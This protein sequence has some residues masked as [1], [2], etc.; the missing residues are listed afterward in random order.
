[1]VDDRGQFWIA[2]VEAF[3]S[4]GA[5][6]KHYCKRHGLTPRTFRTWRTRIMGG[7]KPIALV[8]HENP[9]EAREGTKT[10]FSPFS[11]SHPD[12]SLPGELLTNSRTRRRW[13]PEQKQQIV[14]AALRSGMSLERFS[15]VLGLTPSVV[16]RWKHELAARLQ[17]EHANLPIPPTAP[18]FATVHV[19]S[20]EQ[21]L[22][23][24]DPVDRT[25]STAGHDRGHA[26]QRPPAALSCSDRTCRLA[27]TAGSPGAE[28]LIT[29]PAGVRIHLAL[30]ATDMRKGLES[31]SLLV[32]EVLRQD[33]FGG[34]LFIFRGSDRTE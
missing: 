6:Q 33:P 8:S 20:N 10:D 2:H 27:S 16:H 12:R 19:G 21:E 13:T 15:R 9:I 17:Q 32:Q 3:Q 1:M 25:A 28:S 30:G 5:S 34:H 23:V 29:V 18:S 26:R 24:A 22:P 7:A 31:L 4:T 14:L 11:G